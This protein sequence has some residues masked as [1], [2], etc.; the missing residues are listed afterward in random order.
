MLINEML[1]QIFLIIKKKNFKI[2][3]NELV[4]RF[5][6]KNNKYLFKV[7]MFLKFFD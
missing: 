3:F 2:Y 4:Q 6:F 1:N 7:N 5:R